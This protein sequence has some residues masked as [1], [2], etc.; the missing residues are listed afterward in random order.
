MHSRA[1]VESDHVIMMSKQALNQG[2][3]SLPRKR[4]DLENPND[5]T[6]MSAFQATIDA[7]F[8]PLATL[9]DQDANL[10]YMVTYFNKAGPDIVAVLLDNVV[11]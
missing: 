5:L 4:F 2:N 6:Q 11:R 1:D 10:D 3:Q 7:K 9:V 8:K